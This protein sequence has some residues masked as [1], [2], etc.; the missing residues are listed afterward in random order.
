MSIVTA[1]PEAFKSLPQRSFDELHQLFRN[2][3]SVE[4]ADALGNTKGRFLAW[5]PASRWCAKAWVRLLF[6]Q[7]QGK[8]FQLTSQRTDSGQGVNLFKGGALR[9]SFRTYV[10]AARF[11][12]KPCLRLDYS[13]D[14]LMRGLKDD[15]RRI[16]KDLLLGQIYYQFFWRRDP[17]FLL[18]F[19]LRF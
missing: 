19:A 17:E 7:W 15:V 9:Y 14:G 13:A 3:S 12:G 2:G 11:D 8:R 1:S 6:R 4:V 10:C 16:G 5:N 18:Y